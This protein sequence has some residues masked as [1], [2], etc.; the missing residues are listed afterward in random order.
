M[1]NYEDG[2]IIFMHKFYGEDYTPP[3]KDAGIISKVGT[4]YESRNDPFSL[5]TLGLTFAKQKLSIKS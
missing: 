1:S 4:M 3:D 5:F 2:C